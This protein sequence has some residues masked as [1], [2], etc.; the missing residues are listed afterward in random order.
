MMI[1]GPL[2]ERLLSG[3]FVC[4]VTAPEDFARLQDETI[5][6]ALNDY[7]R[8]LNRRIATSQDGSVFFLA[9]C[10]LTPELRDQLRAQFQVTLNSLLP[11]LDWMQL[12]QEVLGKDSTVAPGDTLKL[13]EFVQKTEDHQGLRQRF[14]QL[15]S[16][17]F[18]N[19][20]A[21]ALDA[22]V[23][24]VFRRLK[25]HGY[26]EQP[27]AERQFYVVTG[28]VD[29]LLELIRFIRDEENLPVDDTTAQEELWQ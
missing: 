19:S 27:H 8:P 3:Q 1:H 6:Q 17:R 5:L 25:E 13:H 20:Q 14:S 10:E 2:V 16:D 15:A 29:Y 4:A 26:L 23:K 12:V 9:W 21:E 7:L 22:Q 24:T 28:K 18:F 11:L